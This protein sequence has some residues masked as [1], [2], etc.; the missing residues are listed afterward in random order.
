MKSIKAYMPVLLL[1]LMTLMT[2]TV[3]AQNTTI[4]F[5]GGLGWYN[6][7]ITGTAVIVSANDGNTTLD[8][9]QNGSHE[10]IHLRYRGAGQN[11]SLANW[12]STGQTYTVNFEAN[13]Q[14]DLT[15][16]PDSVTLP[17]HSVWVGDGS[18]PTFHMEG[19]MV[20]SIDTT[21]GLPMGSHVIAGSLDTTCTN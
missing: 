14:Y 13:G 9:H 21:T 6:P 11:Y 1:G 15:A 10:A 8:F 16:L 4:S 20:I 7:C 18:A 3:M 19:D 17:F 12:Q 5:D 2:G